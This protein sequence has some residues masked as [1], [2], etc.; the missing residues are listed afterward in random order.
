[1]SKLFLDIFNLSVTASWLIAAVIAVRFLFRKRVPKWVNCLMWGIVGLRLLIP[2]TIES[3]LSLVPS[4]ETVN[5]DAVYADNDDIVNDGNNIHVDDNIPDEYI[6]SG[7][8]VLDDRLNPVINGAISSEIPSEE[9][10]LHKIVNI[11][12]YIW[13]AGTVILLV[14]AVI[15]YLFLKY[16]V[17]AAIPFGNA[18]RKSERVD[19]PF[20]LGFFRPR[21]YLPFGLSPETEESVVAHEN[22]HIKRKDHLIK[23]LA[24]AL[25]SVYWFN[26]LV[27]VAYTLLCRDIE[28]ACDEKVIKNL[29]AEAR[30]AYA[31]ALLECSMRRN[32]IAACPLAFGEIGVKDRVKNTMSYKKPTFWVIL[33]AVIV[34]VTVSVLFLTS[35]GKAEKGDTSETVSDDLSQSESSV[36][37]DIITDES[38]PA[39]ES[40]ISEESTLDEVS[41][42]DESEVSAEN[43]KEEV[44]VKL[45]IEFASEELLADEDA[46]LLYDDPDSDYSFVAFTTDTKVTNVRF[47]SVVATDTWSLDGALKID[48][49]LYTLDEFTPEMVFVAEA[50]FGDV[51]PMRGIS[52][53]DTNGNTQ[54]YS[55]WDSAVDASIGLSRSDIA[56]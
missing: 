54:Y 42:S 7:I 3:S 56:E 46:F 34:C 36:D 50:V 43:K 27:W 4:R 23:P 52:F 20:V 35:P 45:S 32:Y 30:K 18:V 5:T 12:S 8:D 51:Y 41:I 21:I 40:N 15:N 14:Y 19:T 38:K 53:V 55:L 16:R 49:V 33:S 25:L 11:A 13:L 39:E 28:C 31:S 10:P 22:A 24:Y 37:Q 17:S 29:N 44:K 1:M 6:Q 2:F 48:E 9:T 47:F 26:P